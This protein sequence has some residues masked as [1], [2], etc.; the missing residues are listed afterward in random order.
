MTPAELKQPCE[1]VVDIPPG[2]LDS[3]AKTAPLWGQDR[4]ALGDCSRKAAALVKVNAA[5]ERQINNSVSGT[6]P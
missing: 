4:A 6:R 3:P 2:T 5:L 1:D